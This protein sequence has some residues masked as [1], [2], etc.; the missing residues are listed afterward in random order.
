VTIANGRLLILIE[1]EKVEGRQDDR[2]FSGGRDDNDFGGNDIEASET[3]GLTATKS[4]NLGCV[5]FEIWDS[6]SLISTPFE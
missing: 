6:K 3:A 1:I 2:R 4:I 5:S